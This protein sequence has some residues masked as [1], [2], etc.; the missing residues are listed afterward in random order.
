LFI[1]FCHQKA[2]RWSYILD[3]SVPAPIVAFQ[4]RIFR[5]FLWLLTT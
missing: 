4:F 2:I 3:E 5:L 1:A